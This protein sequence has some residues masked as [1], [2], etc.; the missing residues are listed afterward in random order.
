MNEVHTHSSRLCM[1]K[2]SVF[3]E[4]FLPYFLDLNSG[5]MREQKVVNVSCFCFCLFNF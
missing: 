4:I 5:P 3:S 1:Q 2:K